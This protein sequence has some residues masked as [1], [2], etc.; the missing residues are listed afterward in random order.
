MK[1]QIDIP[2]SWS[3]NLLE[4]NCNAKELLE[5]STDCGFGF[6]KAYDPPDGDLGSAT[7]PILRLL[8]K[9][10]VRDNRKYEFC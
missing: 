7:F 4:A 2:R 9:N 10:R 8:K 6:I 5:I 3:R 1:F